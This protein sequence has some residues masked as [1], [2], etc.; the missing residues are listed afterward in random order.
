MVSCS[1]FLVTSC[2]TTEEPSLAAPQ[3]LVYLYPTKVAAP[4]PPELMTYKVTVGLD[5]PSNFRKLQY[6]TLL[7]SDYIISLKNTINY[8]ES[9]IDRI[10]QLSSE[11]DED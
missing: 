1:V 5:E 9:E 11:K 10:T 4:T 3:K 7:M 6:N 8:Y 2:C